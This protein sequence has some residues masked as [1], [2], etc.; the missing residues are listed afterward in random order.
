[1]RLSKNIFIIL[2]L[3]QN[4]LFAGY[5]C[6]GLAISREDGG[7]SRGVSQFEKTVSDKF[8]NIQ[9]LILEAREYLGAINKLQAVKYSS[10]ASTNVLM[11]DSLTELKRANHLQENQN[12]LKEAKIDLQIAKLNAH[13]VELEQLLVQLKKNN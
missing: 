6:S 10:N 8:R 2:L 13:I 3:L 11:V 5:C 9:K 7:T 12:K 1:M 4:S